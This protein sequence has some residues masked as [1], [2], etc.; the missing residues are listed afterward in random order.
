VVAPVWLAI[1]KDRHE[2]R[3]Q[4]EPD[5]AGPARQAG[6]ELLDEVRRQWVDTELAGSLH[7]LAR[8][9]LGMADAP[10]RSGI[11]CARS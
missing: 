7:H 2:R 1:A 4:P 6:R 8:I 9:E 10:S 3:G 11:P 5:A